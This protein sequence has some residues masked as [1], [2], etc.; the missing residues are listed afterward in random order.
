MSTIINVLG[1]RRSGTTMLHLMLASGQDAVACD[2]IAAWFRVAR[3]RRGSVP[4]PAFQPILPTKEEKFHREVMDQYGVNYVVDSSKGIDWVLDVTRWGEKQHMRVF[5]V[6]IWK[7][8]MD[9]AFSFWKRGKPWKR[10]YRRY[11]QRLLRTGLD[12]IT[13]NYSELVGD[14]QEKLALICQHVGMPYFEGKERF[15]EG[16]HH[17]AGSSPGVSRQVQRGASRI[18]RESY[19][20]EFKPVAE[21]VKR[22]LEKDQVLQEVLGALQ[23]REV[24]SLTVPRVPQSHLYRPSFAE[25]MKYVSWKVVKLFL[26]RARWNVLEPRIIQPLRRVQERLNL[27]KNVQSH[28]SFDPHASR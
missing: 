8:P 5:N 1:L 3:H 19:P 9:Q 11:H 2:E 7:D 16:E 4:P 28:E 15:W 6:L 14:P 17:V 22:V 18:E 26:L 21:R 25:Q 20:P 27:F 13:V 10:Q 23:E 12:F 24:S